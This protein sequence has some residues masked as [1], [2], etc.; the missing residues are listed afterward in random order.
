MH[1]AG[2]VFLGLG[3]VMLVIGMVM[4]GGGRDSLGDAGDSFEDLGDF[5]IENT[6]SGTVNVT[7]EDGKGDFGFTFWIKGEYL[8]EDGDGEWDHCATTN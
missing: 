7:D 5:A 6:N 4:A 8:D 3:V 2:K 1:I